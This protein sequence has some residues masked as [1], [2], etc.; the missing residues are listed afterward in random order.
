MK[1]LKL[2]L[3]VLAGC[4]L[5]NSC[6]LQAKREESRRDIWTNKMAEDWYVKQGWLVG[7]NFIP[8]NAINQLEMWQAETFDTA[9]IDKELSLAEGLGMNTVRV[10]LHD[11][12]YAQ[13]SAGFA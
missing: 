10:F 1:F 2:Y 7:A 5:F 8:S 6:K 12:L 3:I 4:A 9:T 13:D 11:L